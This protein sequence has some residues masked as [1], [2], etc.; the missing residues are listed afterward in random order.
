[1]LNYSLLNANVESGPLTTYHRSFGS[2]ASGRSTYAGIKNYHKDRMKSYFSI[3]RDNYSEPASIPFTASEKEMNILLKDYFKT[4]TLEKELD[5]M[6]TAKIFCKESGGIFLLLKF[7]QMSWKILLKGVKL[8]MLKNIKMEKM[9][10]T[11]E[12]CVDETEHSM[13]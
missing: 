6:T 8:E 2:F 11:C 1:M 12:Y 13:P 10:D 3:F 7:C 4:I 9:K 5:A